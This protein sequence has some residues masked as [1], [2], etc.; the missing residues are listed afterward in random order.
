[1]KLIGQ[2]WIHFS[3]KVRLRYSL[4]QAASDDVTAVRGDSEVNTAYVK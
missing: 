3:F 4:E 1:M 2:R